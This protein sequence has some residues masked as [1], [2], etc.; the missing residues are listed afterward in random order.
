MR[1]DFL[2]AAFGFIL[3]FLFFL[4]LGGIINYIL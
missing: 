1:V 3:G 4:I 2:S